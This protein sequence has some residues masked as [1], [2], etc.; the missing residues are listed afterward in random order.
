MRLALR[1]ANIVATSKD[2]LWR[3]VFRWLPLVGEKTLQ[4]LG[5][6]ICQAFDAVHDPGPLEN[7]ADSLIIHRFR[8]S[9]AFPQILM[10]GESLTIRHDIEVR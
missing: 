6:A 7:W 1:T 2:R 8:T 9:T 5:Y 3:W 4:L 10:D